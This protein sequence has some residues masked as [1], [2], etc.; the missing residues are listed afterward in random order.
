MSVWTGLYK[1]WKNRIWS[2]LSAVDYSW[3]T[4][5]KMLKLLQKNC[6]RSDSKRMP[7]SKPA[8]F[9]LPIYL[10]RKLTASRKK[11]KTAIYFLKITLKNQEKI[12]KWDGFLL[13]IWIRQEMYVKINWRKNWLE[14]RL[15]VYKTLKIQEKTVKGPQVKI[16]S[17]LRC[18]CLK[19]GSQ[20]IMER[21]RNLKKLSVR[22]CTAK[23]ASLKIK[24]NP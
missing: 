6:W 10:A 8:L 7:K 5:I 18:R 22:F 12:T 9:K 11:K 14:N 24:R 3:L 16:R 1:L 2:T 19:M 23:T 13:M 21:K 17:S 15:L 20:R 4:I